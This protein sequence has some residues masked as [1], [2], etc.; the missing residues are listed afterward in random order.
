MDAS[1]DYNYYNTLQ[2]V[3]L[4]SYNYADVMN[5]NI[6]AITNSGDVVVYTELLSAA[7]EVIILLFLF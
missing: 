1:E 5:I 6:N 3:F 7:S 4:H 2:I